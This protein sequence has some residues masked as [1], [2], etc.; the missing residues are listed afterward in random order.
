MTKSKIAREQEITEGATFK[1]KFPHRGR[2]A[3]GFLA[4]FEGKLVAYQ[5]ECRHL[6]LSLDFGNGKFFTQDGKNFICQTHNAIYDPLTGLCIR[7][8][9]EGQSLRA[10]KIE[11]SEGD[12][13]LLT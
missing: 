13:W 7:G 3:D 6:P 5:N 2:M 10:L 1:F 11:V 9:C 4:R 12:V 8:P